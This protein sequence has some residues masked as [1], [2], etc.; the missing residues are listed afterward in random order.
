MFEA[1]LDDC[2][3]IYRWEFHSI[4]QRMFLDKHIANDSNRNRMYIDRCFDKSQLD[5]LWSVSLN[6]IHTS[7]SF[8]NSNL[9]FVQQS[10]D[11]K[12]VDLRT[13]E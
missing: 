11:I 2:S 13:Q 6:G 4:D 9:Y 10:D 8:Y 12:R 1:M 5:T 3:S 7:E